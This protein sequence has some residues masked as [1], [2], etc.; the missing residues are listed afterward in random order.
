MKDFIIPLNHVD[1]NAKK[2]FESLGEIIDGSI[3]Y[4]EPQGG[5]P[6]EVHTSEHNHLFIVTQGQVGIILGEKE[7]VLNK[8]ESFLAYGKTPHS[9][10]N[11]ID[12]TTVM[13]EY[14]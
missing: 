8:D 5:D 2:F 7:V 3:A 12:R 1:F 11:N 9:V 14:R 4:V 13:I 6:V 10:W